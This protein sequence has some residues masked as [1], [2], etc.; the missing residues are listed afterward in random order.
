MQD[1]WADG[2]TP[3]KRRFGEPFT[4]PVIPLGA[5][6][7]HHSISSKDISRLHQIG[8]EVFSGIFNGYPLVA[9]GIWKGDIV[10]ADIEELGTLDASEIHARRLNAKEVLTSTKREGGIIFPL[11]DGPAKLCGRDHEVRE[12]PP[13]Q[14]QLVMSQDLKEELHGNSDRSQPTETHDDA[15]ARNDFW[16]IQGDFIYRRHTEPRVH[17]YVPKEE[18][19]PIP[20][21]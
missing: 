21:K 19:F 9:G 10:V 18:T 16:S 1:L 7:E 5:M 2:K 6:V 8:E 11:A 12:S 3:Y 15:E 20:L 4:G 17:L 14:D 13:R